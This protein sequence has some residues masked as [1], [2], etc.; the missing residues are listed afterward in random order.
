LDPQFADAF[1][2]RG[3]TKEALR[4]YAGALADYDA[5]ARIEPTRGLYFRRAKLKLSRR[6][7]AG[8]LADLDAISEPQRTAEILKLRAEV[9]A[10][11]RDLPGA[12]AE[13]D[14]ALKLAPKDGFAYV[15][16]ATLE[17]TT[18]KLDDALR[19]L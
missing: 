8:A 3:A 4:D 2:F 19:D 6:D 14:Q 10:T 7:A 18:G 1:E 11:L 9:R 5:A 16:R 15:V 17:I 12:F 13:L